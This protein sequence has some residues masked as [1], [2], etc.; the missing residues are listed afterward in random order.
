MTVPSVAVPNWLTFTA[1]YDGDHEAEVAALVALVEYSRSRRLAE[2]ATRDAIPEQPRSPR[3]AIASA[4]EQQEVPCQ[5]TSR[6]AAAA[7]RRDGP[8]VDDS[9]AA[10]PG[11][12]IP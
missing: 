1:E 7:R 6:S 11:P 3:A 8:G 9:P 2:R 12:A 4:P 5:E 10:R